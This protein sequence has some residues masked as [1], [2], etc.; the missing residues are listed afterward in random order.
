MRRLALVLAA[1]ALAGCAARD[2][3][4]HGPR[5]E[6]T[7]R[8]LLVFGGRTDV[9]VFSYDRVSGALV[10][11]TRIP[12]PVRTAYLA[13]S[14]DRRF[15]FAGNGEAP[16]R[17]TAFALDPGGGLRGLNEQSTATE[18]DALGISHVAVHPNGR[19]LLTAHLKSGRISVLPIGTD[20][21]LGPPSFSQLFAVGAHQ[22]VIDRAGRHAHIPV[23][24][25]QFVASFTIDTTAGRLVPAQPDRV[26]SA[27]GSGPRHLAFTPDE[28][29]AYVNNEASG[30]VT[31][32]RHEAGRLQPLVTVPT[33]PAGFS[34]TGTGHILV[35]PGGR[36]VY[37]SNRFHGSIAVH[38]LDAAT[39]GLS[40]AEIAT[41]GG[42][43]KF[44][45]DFD[46]APGGR[47]MF[48]GNEKGDS[49]SVLRVDPA[50][51]RLERTGP[52]VPAPHA[53]QVLVAI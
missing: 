39:G 42:D 24:D 3:G 32:Y 18:G 23:R 20:G 48:V 40:L 43:L 36:F 46:L 51:G 6:G 30:T 19:W 49:I 35:H 28:R 4:P 47:L 2:R 21:R 17:V 41:A 25:G 16:G 53:P 52:P 8:G 29:F 31:A 45:R 44:P 11:R 22:V 7:A 33:V 1:A 12:M 5:P 15:V 26:A 50:S 9:A 27:P 13:V 37:T 14:P 10:E 34:E 38:A